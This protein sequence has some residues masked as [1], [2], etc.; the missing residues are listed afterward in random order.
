MT[1]H[2]PYSLHLHVKGNGLDLTIDTAAD[3]LT[4]FDWQRFL[5]DYLHTKTPCTMA[6]SK[7]L[8]ALVADYGA[9]KT[10]RST[11]TIYGVTVSKVRAFDPTATLSSVTPNWLQAFEAHFLQTMSQ[12]GI[13]I[14]LRNLR[15][16][17]NWAIANGLTDNYPFRQFRIREERVPIRNLTVEQ[18][19]SLRDLPLGRW[20]AM[21]RD[22]FL[23]SLFLCG[24]NAGDLLECRRLTHGRIV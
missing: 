18:I 2:S 3:S 16:T 6:S 4:Q 17:F 23:L 10:N 15:T 1:D 19:R 24:V 12:N 22:L 13:A 8:H 5:N 11:A 20:Q 21:Y 14:H 9:L 7:P